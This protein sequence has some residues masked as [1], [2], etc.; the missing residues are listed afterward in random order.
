MGD[1]VLSLD[2]PSVQNVLEIANEL[3]KENKFLDTHTLYQRAKKRLK[4]PRKG[5]LKIIQLLIDNKVLVDGS[6]FTRESVLDNPLRKYVYQVILHNVG[7]H[8]SALKRRFSTKKIG[9]TGQLIWH[10]DML[11]K[12]NI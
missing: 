1:I 3:T 8:F 11:I 4:I 5:L 10:L 7:I 9:S 12:F 2:H 6:R